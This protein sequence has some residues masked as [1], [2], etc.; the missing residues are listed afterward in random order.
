MASPQGGPRAKPRGS[1]PLRPRREVE[2]PRLILVG[3]GRRPAPDPGVRAHVPRLR[4]RA[5][6]QRRGRGA[7]RG[8]AARAVQAVPRRAAGGG[9]AAAGQAGAVHAAGPVVGVGGG[10][11]GGDGDGDGDRGQLPHPGRRVRVRAVGVRG[12][13]GVPAGAGAGHRPLARA[14]AGQRAAQLHARF[15]LVHV[16]NLIGGGIPSWRALLAAAF[17]NLRPGGQ[18]EFTE[19]RPRFFDLDEAGAR[20]GP[21]CEAY[22]RALA[23]ACARAGEDFDPAPKVCAWLAAMGADVVRERVDWLPVGSWGRDAVMRRKGALLGEMLECG[24]ENWT[25]MLFGKAGWREHDTRALLERVKSE[26]RDPKLRS[27]VKL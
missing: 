20:V 14:A 12:G 10:G 8:A 11:G 13:G 24:F 26:V 15:D 6:A 27:Y 16:R 23:E 4:A 7:A 25:L 19:V 17:A 3:R 1:L 9:A 22:Q 5:G 18:L 21:A 2:P